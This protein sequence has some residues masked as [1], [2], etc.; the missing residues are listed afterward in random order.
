MVMEYMKKGNLREYLRKNRKLWFYH[1][2]GENKLNFLQKIIQ[3]LKDIHRKKLVHRDFHSG[4]IIVDDNGTNCNITDLGL[5]KPV[6]ETDDSK[7]FGIMP[8]MAPEVL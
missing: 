1:I 7:V 8:Y 5:A 4:N 3:G 6:N 2:S